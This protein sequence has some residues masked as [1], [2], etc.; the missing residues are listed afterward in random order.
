MDHWWDHAACAGED[1]EQFFPEE[2]RGPKKK[3]FKSL[4][5]VIW[6]FC[7]IC[8]VRQDCLK[9]AMK[10]S[11]LDRY[12]TTFGIWGGTT[13]RMRDEILNK[14]PSPKA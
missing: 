6:A 12:N 8:P 2:K 10:K 3:N 1:V 7:A 4:P 11:S 9:D 14:K 13:K 5:D